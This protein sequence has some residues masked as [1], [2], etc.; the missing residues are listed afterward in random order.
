[1]IDKALD[2]LIGWIVGMA[3]RLGRYVAQ[4]GVPNDPN[5]R[6][7]LAARD[8][9]A[10]A[11][12]LTGRVSRALLDPVLAAL[13]VRYGLTVLQPFEQNG[14]WWVRATLNPTL[15]Q[16]LGVPSGEAAAGGAESPVIPR[17]RQELAARLRG[18]LRDLAQLG[19]IVDAVFSRFRPEGLRTM[20]VV[21]EGRTST[22]K[23]SASPETTGG[24]FD[25][26]STL[27]FSDL[28]TEFFKTTILVATINGRQYRRLESFAGVHAEDLLL[29][30]L[31][32]NWDALN[33]PSAIAIDIN[34][35][36]CGPELHNC[37]GKLANFA[38]RR[39]VRLTVRAANPYPT[40]P[41]WFEAL[42]TLKTE[43]NIDLRV[44]NIM[45]TLQSRYGIDPKD[46]S[47]A[48]R[49]QI[50]N[51]RKRLLEVRSDYYQRIAK[52]K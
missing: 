52:G 45:A 12:R 8:A 3:R 30:T 19:A 32:M 51:R 31:E 35:L 34:R 17:V 9:V 42:K 5:E 33:R 14:R 16:D 43:P 2:A 36:P 26:E 40:D 18:R 6:L 21:D 39:G 27:D 23:I 37:A 49:S 48:V 15:T 38:S 22:I 47:P 28:T 41:S 1:P 44:W 46:I 11:R 10:A 25:V 20:R 50:E 4:A 13:R 24:A 29:Q 7:R